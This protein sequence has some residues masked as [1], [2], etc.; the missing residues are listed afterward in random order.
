MHSPL[1]VQF[2]IFSFIAEELALL[3]NDADLFGEPAWGRP[4]QPMLWTTD[5]SVEY[6][7]SR[8]AVNSLL[9]GNILIF[10]AFAAPAF[11]S[12]LALYAA[13]QNLREGDTRHLCSSL[14]EF[15]R[16]ANYIMSCHYSPVE[17]KASR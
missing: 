13:L 6:Q 9:R 17:D 8:Y 16:T 15:I 12:C 5:C 10:S 2:Q 7:D 14:L 11:G 3:N 4:Q 1:K